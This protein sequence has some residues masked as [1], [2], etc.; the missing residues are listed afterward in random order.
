MH[1]KKDTTLILNEIKRHYKFETNIEFASFLGIAPTTLSSWYTRNSIDYDLVFA[2]YEEIN[3]NWLLTGSGPMLRSQA[4]EAVVIHDNSINVP[5]YNDIQVAAG[6]GLYNSEPALPDSSICL[7]EHLI[8][9]SQQYVCV[10]V[11][12]ES[13]APTIQDSSYIIARLLDKG[14]WLYMPDEHIYIIVSTDGMAY[15]KRIKNRWDQNFIV[16][17]SDNP[18]KFT[19]SNFNLLLN[20]VQHIWHVEWYIS[21]RM[22]NIHDQF[23]SRLKRLEDKI[24]Q[25]EQHLPS[26]TSHTH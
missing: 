12:G 18:E 19:Y 15:L 1:N 20:E 7:P 2:K 16:L 21:A 11:K 13:M 9:R 4:N 25:I 6:C 26:N 10:R 3:A 22:P 8:K 5:L 14:D 23:Y 17:M 24:E